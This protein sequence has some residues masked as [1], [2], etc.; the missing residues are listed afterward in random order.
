MRTNKSIARWTTVLGVAAIVV[1]ALG[2]NLA[3]DQGPPGNQG[4]E[5][6]LAHP[7]PA[8]RRPASTRPPAPATD[9]P[10]T[11]VN[12]PAPTRGAETEAEA[13]AQQE[14]ATSRCVDGVA[15]PSFLELN[16]ND[17][18]SLEIV[19]QASSTSLRRAW[20]AVNELDA[21]AQP[22]WT[23]SAA[24]VLARQE[25]RERSVRRTRRRLAELGSKRENWR[26]S[27]RRSPNPQ[28]EET[29]SHHTRQIEMYQ[30][31][32]AVSTDIQPTLD[33]QDARPIERAI[34][35]LASAYASHATHFVGLNIEDEDR[36]RRRLERSGE[37]IATGLA[38]ARD[39]YERC[40][41]DAAE[42]TATES[43]FAERVRHYCLASS[44]AANGFLSAL[45]SQS[46]GS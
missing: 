7:Q 36:C 46:A 6:D 42:A 30:R 26:S 9:E 43:T 16:D 21:I 40:A 8:S 27:S 3:A 5:S 4:S 24:S 10:T 34:A 17:E 38:E 18:V 20:H 13:A 25:S 19:L 12:S 15:A 14:V 33:S 29:L 32:I 44:A 23:P 39:L 2:A 28:V 31:L 1:L 41:S 37:A 11:G 22:T 35:H 45:A